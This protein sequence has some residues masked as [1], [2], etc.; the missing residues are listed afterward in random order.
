MFTPTGTL[1]TDQPGEVCHVV[2]R[3][4]ECPLSKSI[5]VLVRELAHERLDTHHRTSVSFRFD[6]CLRIAR[7]RDGEAQLL[8]GFDDIAENITYS[9][10]RRPRALS[11]PLDERDDT[12]IDAVRLGQFLLPLVECSSSRWQSLHLSL[13]CPGCERPRIG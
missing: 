8:V 7:F 6:E 2:P 1:C 5:F 3:L 13:D 11:K 10:R 12:V 9:V 4:R